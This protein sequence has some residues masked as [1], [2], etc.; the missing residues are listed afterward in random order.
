[1]ASAAPSGLRQRFP[2]QFSWPK[3]S[4]CVASAQCL[5]SRPDNTTKIVDP[6][7]VIAPGEDLYS[8]FGGGGGN[9]TR[10]AGKFTLGETALV[11]G[12]LTVDDAA[13]APDTLDVWVNPDVSGGIAGLGAPDL[14]RVANVAGASGIFH[15]GNVSYASG[16]TI[17]G[18]V[19]HIRIS[20]GSDPLGDASRFTTGVA[21]TPEAGP[22]LAVSRDAG[23]GDLTFTWDSLVGKQYDLLSAAGLDTPPETWPVYQSHE[24]ILASGTGANTLADVAPDG[25]T[26][27][28]AL[29]SGRT[30]IEGNRRGF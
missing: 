23:T 11:L 20:D 1:M 3:R 27:F 21:G 6:N 25:A 29:L 24:D 8:D 16:G 10:V 19:D 13:N 2:P 22:L 26:R 14:T 30:Q 12:R 15:L 28:F 17:G 9:F 18:I 4:F 5:F 7:R